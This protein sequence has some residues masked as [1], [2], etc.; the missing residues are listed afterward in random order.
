MSNLTRSRRFALTV[1][2]ACWLA[3][4]GC[5]GTEPSRRTPT[6]VV[7][8]QA[9]VSFVSIG[10]TA[11]LTAAVLDQRGD[12]IKSAIVAWSSNNLAVATVA[13]FGAVSAVITSAGNGTAQVT[14]TS[15]AASGTVA[16][17]VAQ[18]AFALLKFGGDF[19]SGPV[20]SKL[21]LPLTARVTDAQGS[22]VAGA[23]VDFVVA[24]GGGTLSNPSGATN[25]NGLST[26]EWTIG[27]STGD[28]QQVTVSLPGTQVPP[29]TF[30]A[31]P[32]AG[33]PDTV[34]K[35]AGD[36]QTAA[37]GTRVATAP[38]VQVRDSFGNPVAGA[39][40]TFAPASGGG[41][42]QDGT[43]QTNA[44]GVATVGRWTL[45]AAGGENTLTATVTGSGIGGNPVTFTATA[46]VPGPPASIVA[47]A[48]DNQTGLIGFPLN[49]APSVLVRDAAGIPVANAQVDFVAAT[50]GGSVTGGGTTTSPEG[51]ATVGSWTVQFGGNTLTATVAGPPF[52]GNPLTFSA[53][54]VSGSFNIDIRYLVPVSAARAQV[55]NDAAAQ[56]Q[57][58]IYRDIPDE[59]NFIIPAGQCGP[60]APAFNETVDD[61]IILV[62]LDSIDGPGQ[63]LGSAGPCWIRDIGFLPLLGLMR[64]DT[65]D[66]ASLENRG[67]FDEVIL[68]EM[69]HVL[70]FGTIWSPSLLNLRADGGG[71][72]PHFTG[73][74]ALAAF[75]RT[76]GAGYTGGAKVPLENIGGAGTRD[77]HWRE[78]VF[79][80]E[81]MTGFLNSNVANPLSLVTVASMGDEA[82]TVNHAGAE[83]YA[84]PTVALRAPG[85]P[86]TGLLLIDDIL[87]LPIYRILRGRVT[88]VYQNY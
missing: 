45:G 41:S 64:F 23:A 1:A 43:A 22:P 68:H 34:F 77:S 4:A 30:T 84:L 57:Q 10:A 16:V 75:D 78:S 63:I 72:D 65:A 66:V 56:W 76:G 81:L 24:T 46:V 61:V 8:S 42:V 50:G 18:A 32:V 59:A 62:T 38:A 55:F 88:G 6:T 19:Q 40:V 21:G 15:G 33:P 12:T 80:P 5:K 71:A 47:V 13:S 20:G 83:P 53:S 79:G 54:G 52:A 73:A 87:H 31:I 35:Q 25:S 3:L 7:F 86:G 36:S 27:T 28:P 48:G 82:Y 17:S 44:T 2:G 49:V 11:P 39:T 60:N 67:Q 74:Q 37:V 29:H 70:G 85:A 14:A 58:L 26:I 9:A 69:L 51:F